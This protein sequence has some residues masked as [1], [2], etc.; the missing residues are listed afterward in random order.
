M[1]S[2]M[3][4]RIF[5]DRRLAVIYDHLHLG[6][7]DLNAYVTMVDEFGARSLLDIGCGTG[8]F[9]CLMAGRGIDV[10]GLDPARAS[11]DVAR[12]K[13]GGD[14]VRWLHGEPDSLPALC[15]DLVT[16][17]AN[18]AQV[19]LTDD[20][21]N[22]VLGRAYAALR[23]GGRLVFET[24]DPARKA[25]LEWNREISQAHADIP[26]TGGVTTWWDVTGMGEN[27][28]SIRRTFVFD[29][30]AAV[31]TSDATFRFRRREEV[32]DTLRAVGFLLEDVRD[33]PD[34]SG[35]ELVFVARRPD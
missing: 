15:V 3:A 8:T 28:V 19:F 11:L 33:A 14:R 12:S 24:R 4:E 5:E 25:W 7:S 34:R 29:T 32:A 16:M 10:T 21:W 35:R 30:G 31:L 1:I 18:V 20:E 17:T 13:P 6:R 9:A 27:L 22:S 23:P 26:G 2:T